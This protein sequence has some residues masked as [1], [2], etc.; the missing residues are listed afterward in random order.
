[1]RGNRGEFIPEQRVMGSRVV[2][3]LNNQ[4]TTAGFYDLYLKKEENLDKYGFNYDRKES[5]LAFYDQEELANLVGEQVNII[6]GNNSASFAEIIST[7]NQGTPLWKYCL[8]AVLF[9]L[10][11]ETGLLRLWKT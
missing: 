10:A 11:A 3:G 5:Y 8:L 6:E 1:M 9:F 7:Q 2:L 4:I